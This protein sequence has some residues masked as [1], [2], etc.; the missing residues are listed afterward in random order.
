MVLLMTMLRNISLLR[1]DHFQTSLGHYLSGFDGYNHGIFQEQEASQ[2]MESQTYFPCTKIET[3]QQG[4]KLQANILLHCKI[5]GHHQNPSQ[6]TGWHSRPPPSP[7]INCFCQGLH[8]YRQHP[9]S[10]RTIEELHQ[11][12]DIA[13]LHLE[14]RS[15]KAFLTQCTRILFWIIQPASNSQGYSSNELRNAS[16][17][18]LSLWSSTMESMGTFMAAEETSRGSP[19]PLFD[20]GLQ[21]CYNTILPNQIF[22]STLNIGI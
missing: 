15:S 17:L 11:E 22:T 4:H 2:A 14:S 19:L 16:P 20:I 3:C 10:I 1:F 21:G 12:M 7:S 18:I 9:P 6:S 13:S 5:Q 8:N